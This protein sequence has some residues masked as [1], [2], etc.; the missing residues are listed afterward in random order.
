[1]KAIVLALALLVARVAAAETRVEVS[2]RGGGL[3]GVAEQLRE[4]AIPALADI[5]TDLPELP[6]PEVVK[7]IVV[8]DASELAA[9]AP[10]GRGAPAYAVGVAYPDL[11]VVTIATH[12]GADL[13]D[14]VA[15]LRHELGHLALGAAVG[16]R[17][18]RWLH[19][20]FAGQHAGEWS[21]ARMETLAGMAW[22]GGVLSYDELSKSFPSEEAP[23]SHAYAESY[24]FVGFLTRRGRWEDTDDDGDRWP[25]RRFLV[26][27]AHG[28]DIDAAA[29]KAFGKPMRQLWD[30]WRDD[31]GKR[32]LWAPVGV[33]GLGVW[34][35]CALLLTI[36][37]WRK[38]RHNKRRLA[39][40]DKQEK[41]ATS[42]APPPYVPWPGE[43]PF[44][45]DEEEPAGPRLMN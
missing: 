38:R 13:V 27:M 2:T 32:Y 11:G 28:K 45:E 44:N 35:L 26:E 43:D 31:M 10:Q 18:P 30:E 34:V 19:E 22:F 1:M 8:G 33:L 4:A 39:E 20:G 21:Y 36:A 12:R 5:A 3:D 42:V 17:A 6:Q 25:F 7:I 9:A 23:A 14:P 24:D 40:W 15:T 29:M 41:D 37:W 16:D